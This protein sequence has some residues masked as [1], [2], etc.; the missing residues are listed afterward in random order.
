MQ[1]PVLFLKSHVDAFTRKDGVTVAAHETKVQASQPAFA[2]HADARRQIAETAGD[3][4][5]G[6][7]Q[8]DDDMGLSS[9]LTS[10]ASHEDA[11]HHAAGYQQHLEAHGFTKKSEETKQVGAHERHSMHFTHP[12]GAKASV[13]H[14]GAMTK[15]KGKSVPGVSMEVHSGVKN[16]EKAAW[17]GA[18]AAEPARRPGGP[19]EGEIGDH[20]HQTYGVHFKP[21]DSAKDR[22][23]NTHTVVEHNG[24]GVRTMSGGTY[25]PTK[26]TKVEAPANSGASDSP[27]IQKTKAAIT[28]A[29]NGMY[30][31]GKNKAEYERHEAVFEAAVDNLDKLQEAAK[32]ARRGTAPIQQ[33]G[34]PPVAGVAQLSPADKVAAK[35]KELAARKPALDAHPNVI[36]KASNEKE[37]SFDFGGKSYK[38]TGKEGHSFHDS[39]PVAEHESDDGH[40]VW[41]DGQGR[42]HADSAEEAKKVRGGQ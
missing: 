1:I 5:G 2:S 13:A 6:H 20:E 14:S 38:A 40:R 16:D 36:G 29:R 19:G 9:T 21:G 4:T 28:A 8:H 35:R 30:A 3:R 31:A 15:R 33:K 41:K 39:T 27:E 11:K 32:P 42:V 34:A 7:V 24:A 12:S 17:P 18:G 26:L 22:D 10:T 37:H 23:G 25:H